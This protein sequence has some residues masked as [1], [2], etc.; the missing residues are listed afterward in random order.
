MNAEEIVLMVRES[1]Q[2]F[3]LEPLRDG[4]PEDVVVRPATRI[5]PWVNRAYR[6][7][8]RQGIYQCWHKLILTANQASYRLSGNFSLVHE[9]YLLDPT[10]SKKWDISYEDLPRM[11]QPN[12]YWRSLRTGRPT[13][14]G[15]SGN[16]VV[17]DPA[18]D[19]AYSV[20][21]L[22]D[23]V[24]APLAARTDVPRA[25]DVQYHDAVVAGASFYLGRA[26]L[27]RPNAEQGAFMRFTKL[28]QEWSTWQ[29]DVLELQESRFVPADRKPITPVYRSYGRRNF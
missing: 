22:A 7:L 8:V 16:M 18:P 20:Y 24:P 25:L 26:A 1:I 11:T 13:K 5:L 2:I 6:D 17:F 4:F 15:F 12:A 19:R 3:D 10:D 29:S 27:N 28:D 21:F 14:L 9:L 23:T